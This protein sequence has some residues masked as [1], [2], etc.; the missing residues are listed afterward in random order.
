MGLPHATLGYVAFRHSLSY[1]G[2]SI[3]IAHPNHKS[4]FIADFYHF[5]IVHTINRTMNTPDSTV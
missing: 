1:L 4:E 2:L 5:C 3:P